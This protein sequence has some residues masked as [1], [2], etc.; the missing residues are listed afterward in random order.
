MSGVE[1]I[2]LDCVDT[3]STTQGDCQFLAPAIIGLSLF[4]ILTYIY[5]CIYTYLLTPL[6]GQD[7]T[8]CQFFK[9]SLTSLNSWFS[10]S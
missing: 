4:A 7:M 9:R 3:E 2:G 6:L 8:Q 5:I 1:H 10:F